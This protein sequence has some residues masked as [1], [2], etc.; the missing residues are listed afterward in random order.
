MRVQFFKC[1]KCGNVMLK[2]A[3]FTVTPYCCGVPMEEMV[4]NTT[5]GKNEYHLPHITHHDAH[6]ITVQIGKELHPMSPGHF[7]QYFGW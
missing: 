1:P 2:V 6:S 5:E 3:G 7:I 4:P